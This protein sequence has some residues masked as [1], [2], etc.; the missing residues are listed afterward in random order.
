MFPAWSTC[1]RSSPVRWR[2][3]CRKTMFRGCGPSEQLSDPRPLL[4]S[5]RDGR[6][7]PAG[8]MRASFNQHGSRIKAL[9][10]PSGTFSHCSATGEG[11]NSL[12]APLLPQHRRILQ[13]PPNHRGRSASL[14][15]LGNVSTTFFRHHGESWIPAFAG[16]TELGESPNPTSASPIRQLPL[17]GT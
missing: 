11:R 12:T 3:G 14:S 10:R 9:I 5:Q 2:T 15:K 4:P 7:W 8:R 17:Q 6:R 1:R 16:M 13:P